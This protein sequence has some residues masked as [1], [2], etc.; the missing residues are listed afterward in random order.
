MAEG[1]AQVIEHLLSKCKALNSVSSTR[2]GWGEE[3]QNEGKD[4][5]V[6]LTLW[7]QVDGQYFLANAVFQCLFYALEGYYN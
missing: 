7:A 5:R 3:M 2:R 6:F 1:L 4:S